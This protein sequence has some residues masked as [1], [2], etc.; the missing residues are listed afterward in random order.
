MAVLITLSPMEARAAVLTGVE[1]QI[2]S[3]G[4]GLADKHGAN[5]D[6]S[7]TLHIEGAAG[8]MAAAKALGRYWQMPVGTFKA[9]GDVGDFQVRTRSRHDYEL[10]V[11]EGDRDGDAFILVTGS[12]PRFQVHGW[13]RG[14][15]AKRPEWL[16]EHGGRAP[17]WFVPQAQLHPLVELDAPVR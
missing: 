8:E 10:I 9:G 11:R 2:D 14:R 17:A 12:I 7:W 13:M 16:K 15:D 4:R 1:R 6:D 3:L 5:T